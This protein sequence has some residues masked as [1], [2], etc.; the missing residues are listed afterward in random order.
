MRI[1]I[2]GATGFLGRAT[3]RELAGAGHT[4]RAIVRDAARAADAWPG[5][6]V[7]VVE[8]QASDAGFCISAAQGMDA[9]V[10]VAATYT[11]DRDDGSSMSGNA[12]LTRTVLEA[13]RAAGV[14]RVVDISSLV[15]FVLKSIRIDEDTPLTPPG[16]QGWTDPYLRSKVEAEM[17][18]REIE[19][20]GLP[21]ITLHPGTIVGPEDA[22]IGP[23]G[24]LL[25]A[26]L[27]GG[28]L[29]DTWTPWVDVRDVARA[30]VLALDAQ[31][32]SR[33]C[34][35]SGVVAHRETAALL[36]Q[37]TGGSHRRFFLSPASIRRMARLNDLAG[38]RLGQLP[39]AGRLD[40]ML[41][42]P[43]SVDTKRSRA[44]LGL[45]YRPMRDTLSDS[46]RW[47]ADNGLIDARLAGSLP[48]AAPA[49]DAA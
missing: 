39:D 35:T 44:G 18:G 24:R 10:H 23:S 38:G 48:T 49:R 21:R 26:L 15:V 3:V 29:P 16:G 41:D 34:L 22:A 13:A 2:T 42:G 11:Y 40:F 14:G 30:V 32:G 43:R 20:A 31:P 7:E 6:T 27:L 19:A 47:W 37:M 12:T 46:I 4:M 25:L 33:F 1:L 9:V 17:V 28:P 5:S 36:D 45:T 8:G